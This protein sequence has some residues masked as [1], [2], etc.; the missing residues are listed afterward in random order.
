MMKFL[1]GIF[2]D[3][4][5]Y[6]FAAFVLMNLWAWFIVPTFT[7]IT[8]TFPLA[9]GLALILSFCTSGY[10]KDRIEDPYSAVGYGILVN[11]FCLIA[12]FLVKTFLF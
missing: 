12:G 3:V 9:L 7:T 2:I 4:V 5:Q 6:A 8:L 1:I 11:L 10:S